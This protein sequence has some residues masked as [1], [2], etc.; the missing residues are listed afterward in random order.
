[1]SEAAKFQSEWDNRRSSLATSPNCLSDTNSDME[2]SA[3]SITRIA[4]RKKDAVESKPPAFFIDKLN[5][6][7]ASCVWE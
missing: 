2:D 4:G 1:V 5:A 7:H 3:N 6:R